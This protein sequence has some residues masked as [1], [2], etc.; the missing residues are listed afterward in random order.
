MARVHGLG[1]FSSCHSCRGCF[2][3]YPH[4]LIWPLARAIK[5]TSFYILLH[6]RKWHQLFLLT[7]SALIAL[8]AFCWASVDIKSRIWAE[9]ATSW[10]HCGLILNLNVYRIDFTLL[11][12]RK[13]LL[14]ICFPPCCNAI[15]SSK[16]MPGV[17]LC[18]IHVPVILPVQS[19]NTS[20]LIHHTDSKH[21]ICLHPVCGQTVLC[22][23]QGVA[24][25]VII[26][27][28]FTPFLNA[29]GD[30]WCVPSSGIL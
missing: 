1:P 21:Q 15:F 8:V 23:D 25:A 16:N 12:V 2:H 29:A 26:N 22:T 24:F 9:A 14:Y 13:G 5:L 20:P 11:Y 7:H 10:L 6:L 17:V 19:S 28:I 30:G 4:N 27:L 18:F 3:T